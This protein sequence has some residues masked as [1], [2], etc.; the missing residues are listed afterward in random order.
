M[1]AASEEIDNLLKEAKYLNI[2]WMNLWGMIKKY[3]KEYI[4]CCSENH[5]RDEIQ[6]D[7]RGMENTVSCDVCKIYW[8]YDCSD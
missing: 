5:Q 6:H 1:K 2:G 7:K 4:K 8:K 3:P